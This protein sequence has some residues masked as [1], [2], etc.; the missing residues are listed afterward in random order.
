MGR[1]SR[2][3]NLGQ[4]QSQAKLERFCIADKVGGQ[5]RTTKAYRYVF[6]LKLMLHASQRQ[7]PAHLYSHCTH[8]T[9]RE[10]T[11]GG[12]MAL[13]GTSAS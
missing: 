11:V 2:S 1:S 7:V 12:A 3:Q 6:C 5:L 4:D 8:A 13:T 9:E 10:V